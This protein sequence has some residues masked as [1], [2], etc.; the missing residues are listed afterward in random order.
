MVDPDFVGFPMQQMQELFEDGKLWHEILEDEQA[1]EAGVNGS[2]MEP[3]I[4]W[5]KVL[6]PMPEAVPN[7][8]KPGTE[9]C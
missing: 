9:M 7:S 2:N 3:Q 5:F 8:R 1:E 4:D 6:P